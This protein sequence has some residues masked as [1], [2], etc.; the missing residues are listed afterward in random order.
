VGRFGLDGK[1]CVLRAI[2]EAAE[3]PLENEG[4]LGEVLNIVL[5]ASRATAEDDSTV[6]YARAE[7]QGRAQ[8]NCLGN[9]PDCPVSMFNLI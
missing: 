9:Y 7:Y 2:C 1:A 8:G 4:L 6:E 3:Y 5:A